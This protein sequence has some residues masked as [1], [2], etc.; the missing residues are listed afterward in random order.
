MRGGKVVEGV[1]VISKENRH[2]QLLGVVANKET[3]VFS[4]KIKDM[5]VVTTDSVGDFRNFALTGFDGDW[6][7][8]WRTMQFKP[9][10]KE[11]D[12]ITKTKILTGNRVSFKNFIHPNRWVSFYGKYYFITK[13]L[14]D[15]LTEESAHYFKEI[16]EMNKAG[17]V[18]EKVTEYPDTVTVEETK[19]ITVEAFEAVIDFIENKT[20]FPK[21]EHSIS[22]LEKLTAKRKLFTF[23]I[24]PAL[25]FMTRATE[26]AFNKHVTDYGLNSFPAW[27]KGVKWEEGY[28][29]K[30]KRT[31]WNRIVFYQPSVGKQGVAIRF[32]KW[33]K[34]ERVNERYVSK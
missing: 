30:G 7:P 19:P 34:T 13:L 29:P 28:T 31:S 17:L 23:T 14:I 32:R 21:Y 6:Y 4:I 2:G 3:F 9:D 1:S 11:N 26:C 8:G 20:E 5:N 18:L 25:R 12:F 24:I 27:L 10:A 33:Q 15:R 22:N 16:K